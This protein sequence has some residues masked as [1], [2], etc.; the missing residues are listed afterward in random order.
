[1]E[2]LGIALRGLGKALGKAKKKAVNMSDK[3]AGTIGMVGTAGFVVGGGEALK[4]KKKKK[5][6]DGNPLSHMRRR[7]D[8]TTSERSV[9]LFCIASRR[10]SK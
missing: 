1:M 10:R 3:T 9:M 5:K 4:R 8:A 2:G 6:M 7:I